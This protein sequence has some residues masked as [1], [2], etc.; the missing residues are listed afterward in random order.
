MRA[1]EMNPNFIL[2][3]AFLGGV[4]LQKSMYEEALEEFESERQALVSSQMGMF[5]ISIFPLIAYTYALMGNLK[6]A[7]SIFEQV[8]SQDVL[9]FYK[10]PYYF[11]LGEDDKGFEC[12][13]RAFALKQSFMAY[14]K[15]DPL[16][17][18][19]RNDPRFKEILRKMNLE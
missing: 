19:I 4:Y 9:G 2:L 7:E 17:D 15:V 1:I 18:N 11:I 14:I 12:L 8:E 3:H 6:E 5:Q 16:L 13:E 10:A